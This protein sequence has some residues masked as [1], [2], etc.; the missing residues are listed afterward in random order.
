M[1]ISTMLKEDK[2]FSKNELTNLKIDAFSE[3]DK[4]IKKLSEEDLIEVKDNADNLIAENENLLFSRY[5]SASIGMIRRP[6]EDNIHMQ[7]LL[8][9]FYENRNMKVV[10]FLA[11]K[12]L[13]LNEN[14]NALRMLADCYA[15]SGRT[16]E[17]WKILERLVKVDFDE[18]KLVLDL[19]EHF[20]KEGNPDKEL[21]YY[22]K[23]LNRY[24]SAVEAD[25]VKK[26]W[27]IL[28]S[29]KT[30]DDGYFLGIADK[31]AASIGHSFAIDLLNDFFRTIKDDTDKC[32]IVLKKEL[33]LDKECT[34]ARTAL[35]MAYQKKYGTSKRFNYCMK[36]SG[37][38]GNDDVAKAIATFETDIAFD[39]N[40][41]V[42]Q[43]STGKLGIIKDINDEK[44]TISFGKSVSTMSTEMAF[45]AL[46]PM[47]KSHIKV[48][49]AVIPAKL[50]AKILSDTE[51]TLRV[52][53][54]SKDR[55]CSLKDMKAELIAPNLLTEKE[56]D[57]FRKDAKK[58]LL[59]NLYFSP[60]IGET[61][62]YILRDT[63][64]TPEEKQ[65]LS[66]KGE[67]DFYSK[68]KIVIEFVD[69]DFDTE[70][71]SFSEIVKI[72]NSQLRNIGTSITDTQLAS[73]LLL[74]YLRVDKKIA[75]SINECTLPFS[76]IYKKIADKV[77]IFDKLEVPELKKAFIDQVI[78]ADPKGWPELLRDFFPHYT[79]N[80]IPEK[81]KSTRAGYE[82]YISILK[83]SVNNFKDNID[84]FLWNLRYATAKEWEKAGISEEVLLV[85]Q[86]SVLAY[87]QSCI[88]AKKDVTDNKKRNQ[89]VSSSLFVDKKLFDA[90]ENGDAELAK[91]IYSI[92]SN[93]KNLD[94]GR[95]VEIKH[96]IS[97]KY[98]DFSF[99]KEKTVDVDNLIPTGFFCSKESY[100]L[101]VKEKADL[102]HQ[103]LLVADEI[104]DARALGD[105]R[106]NAEYQYGKDKQKNL[107]ITLNNL[108]KLLETAQ[109]KSSKDVD[110]SKVCFG[111]K[112]TM[113]DNIA[114]KQVVY[115]IM[116]LWE[117]DPEN[118]VINFKTPLGTKLYNKVVGDKAKFDINGTKY[119]F[120]ILAID[121]VNF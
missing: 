37:L 23:V 3:Y 42:L 6:Q 97:E 71:D 61:D 10:E 65:L 87:T 2:V 50:K 114:K 101:K 69:S 103:L 117:S 64:I 53:M 110:P 47:P 113:M 72:L 49:K 102:E 94:P 105:L 51:W 17:R 27:S 79:Y 24:I 96:C 100:D 45:K 48:L 7:N 33:V 118:N 46:T 67:N 52:L 108:K 95:L 77:A 20:A 109:I 39:V 62:T 40:C 120:E 80:Y 82:V 12:I 26:V 18:R 13:V 115:T 32:I 106:E 119:D 93:D 60:V 35:V 30:E 8:V 22:K 11:E 59:E 5:V 43:R 1:K 68:V 19:A 86:L 29:K 89:V 99:G 78:D 90:I 41:F 44:V 34:D 104:A 9:S 55:K 38:K 4:Q 15:E 14:K 57:V 25:N 107:N 92:A 70:S 84:I 36:K 73:Y 81:L 58:V 76:A 98:P 28:L 85:T 111:T 31:V 116:G 75:T 83:S 21:F 56:W 54:E 88:E 74:N 112:V 66:F 91:K 63:P 121:V 16:E